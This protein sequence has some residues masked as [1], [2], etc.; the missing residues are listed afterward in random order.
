MN[1][2]EDIPSKNVNNPWKLSRQ[3][4][5]MKNND[6]NSFGISTEKKVQYL[7][8]LKAWRIRTWNKIKIDGSTNKFFQ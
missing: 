1:E 4:N 2:K 3:I 7:N 5:K 8:R 6:I